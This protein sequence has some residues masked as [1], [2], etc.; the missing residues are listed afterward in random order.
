MHSIT[1]RTPF[2]P[3]FEDRQPSPDATIWR[4]R[5]SVSLA[6]KLICDIEHAYA[7]PQWRPRIGAMLEENGSWTLYV[8]PRIDPDSQLLLLML[9]YGA[10]RFADAS[11]WTGQAW[12]TG[13]LL[14]RVL[15]ALATRDHW[16]MAREPTL[17]RDDVPGYVLRLPPQVLP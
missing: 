12:V 15:A 8:W 16:D 11:R 13:E 4:I 5:L 14:A 2:L 6:F 9:D 1:H 17:L 3:T 10:A 7:H